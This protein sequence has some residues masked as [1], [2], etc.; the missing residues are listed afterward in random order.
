LPESA[1]AFAQTTALI[2][3]GSTT[4][5]RPSS[6]ITTMRVE[7]IAGAG[8]EAPVRLGHVQRKHA[9]VGERLPVRRAESARLGHRRLARRHRVALREIPAQAVGQHRLFFGQSE[10]HAQRPRIILEMM[11]RWISFDPAKIVYL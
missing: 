6:C 8:R 2:Q 1:I 7:R 3:Y 9:H 5:A 10:I 4:S 11:L